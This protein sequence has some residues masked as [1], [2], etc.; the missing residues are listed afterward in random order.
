MPV[1]WALNFGHSPECR[2]YAADFQNGHFTLSGCGGQETVI[3]AADW[4]T[5]PDGIP[6][7]P[8][9]P[10]GA[11]QSY[12]H[13][14]IGTCCG[15]CSINATEVRLYYFPDS[16]TGDCQNNQTSNSSSIV[17]GG[18]LGKRVHSLIP[19]GSIA[20]VSGHT[21]LVKLFV[22]Q[23]ICKTDVLIQYLSIGIPPD[24]WDGSCL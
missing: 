3:P 6:Y 5:T 19:D 16:T 17:S 21:L 24:S 4:G 14:Y 12:S 22:F 15:N 7:P 20:V 8:Q 2:S 1:D 10:P 18:N 11:A 23:T 9:I 13:V